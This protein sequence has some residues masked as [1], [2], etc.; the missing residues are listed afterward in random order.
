MHPIRLRGPADVL[1]ALP[2]Q[3][4]YHP[5]DCLVAVALHDRRVGLVARI[6]LPPSGAHEELAAAA[7]SATGPL[8]RERPD[9][10][11]LVGYES[12][13]GQSTPLLEAVD[14]CLAAAALTVADRLV[15]RQGRWY[16][17][18]CEEQDCCPVGG[19]LLSDPSQV[20]AVADFVA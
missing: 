6:D 7:A 12:V 20:P 14:S 18:D 3:L 13:E 8:V 10:V 9:A 5:Q 17:S 19:T 2:Y 4:G 16:S 15:V 11:L 1:A